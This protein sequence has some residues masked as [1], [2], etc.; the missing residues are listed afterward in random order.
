MAF[1]FD[2]ETAWEA[3]GQLTLDVKRKIMGLNAA[4]LYGIEVPQE[5]ALAEAA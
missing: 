1:E 4:K 2:E 5:Y 3:G